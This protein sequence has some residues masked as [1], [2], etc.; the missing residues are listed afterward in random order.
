MKNTA[1]E[2]AIRMVETRKQIKGNKEMRDN[3]TSI[4]T[5]QTRIRVSFLKMLLI[6]NDCKPKSHKR[7]KEIKTYNT[8]LMS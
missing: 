3:K 5:K 2:L 7:T 1:Y 6:S 8:H 4:K